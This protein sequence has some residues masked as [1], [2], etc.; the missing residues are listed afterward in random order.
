MTIGRAGISRGPARKRHLQ[1]GRGLPSLLGNNGVR[2]HF[3]LPPPSPARPLHMLGAD[4]RP[5]VHDSARPSTSESAAVAASMA[6]STDASAPEMKNRPYRADRADLRD[7]DLRGLLR[8]VD[9]K[10]DIG[11]GRAFENTERLSPARRP[12]P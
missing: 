12:D 9:G 2:Q 6:A 1:A 8:L 7:I 11:G 4:D 10:A 3:D 5:A